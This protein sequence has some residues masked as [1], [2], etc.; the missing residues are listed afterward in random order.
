M[1][2]P[3]DDLVTIARLHAAL[4]SAV[5][6]EHFIAEVDDVSPPAQ[7]AIARAAAL[8]IEARELLRALL[9]RHRGVGRSD[10]LSLA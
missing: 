6:T 5:E 10:T 7:Q 1:R 9:L 8:V 2:P 4:D 3:T